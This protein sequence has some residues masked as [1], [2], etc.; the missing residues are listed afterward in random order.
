MQ[1]QLCCGCGHVVA[2]FADIYR[3]AYV[4]L[5]SVYLMENVTANIYLQRAYT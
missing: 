3:V 5:L 1:F 4:S 2:V